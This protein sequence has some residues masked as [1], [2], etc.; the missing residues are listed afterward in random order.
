MH[1]L[2]AFLT[3]K[4]IPLNE[5]E[6]QVFSAGVMGEGL[7]IWPENDTLCAPA[8][9][10]VTM[11]TDTRHAI[12]MT[13]E[14]GMEILLHV[15]LDTVEMNGDGF[16]YLVSEN[17][18]VEAGTALIRFDREKIKAAGHPDVTV[19]IVTDQADVEQVNFHTGMN[20]ESGK[21]VI[22]EF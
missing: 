6:D 3:G 12:G 4:V 1:D 19:C 22:A 18:K 7:A 2:K 8:K 15:G 20:A 10:T 5:V 11:L 21:T 13:L 16:T 17:Q 9:G 14:N